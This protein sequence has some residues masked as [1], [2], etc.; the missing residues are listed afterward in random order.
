MECQAC[1][2]NR[3]TVHLT[4]ISGSEKKEI[5]LCDECAREKGVAMKAT[6]LPE[7]LSSVIVGPVAKQLARM[8]KIAC[9]TCGH[10]YADF[11]TT[12]RLGCPD[13]Y[14]V[15]R[16]VLLPLLERVHGSSRH[17]G[18]V[19]STAGE[20]VV[21]MTEILL[22]RKKLKEAVE[23]EQYEEAARLRDKLKRFEQE[24]RGDA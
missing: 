6:S 11:Q 13:D 23:N 1:H 4:E 19:P 2:K 8:R 14:R 3:A 21:R 12:G 10:T 24:C 9:S 22:L 15:F 18:K 7:I 17:I 5:H 16:K 20:N